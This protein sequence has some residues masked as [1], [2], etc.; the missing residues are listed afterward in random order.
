MAVTE[1]QSNLG[2]TV[3]SPKVALYAVN[4]EQIQGK[5]SEVRSSGR[6]MTTQAP[7][8]V[9]AKSSDNGD[10]LDQLVKLMNELLEA[11]VEMNGSQS[12]LN[13]SQNAVGN[14]MVK[15]AKAQQKKAEKDLKELE[16]KI[17][18]AKHNGLLGKI[19]GGIAA[20]LMIVIGV[21]LADPALA[22]MGG[23]MMAMS[24]G[25]GQEALDKKLENLS[26]ALKAL[27]LVGIAVGA[28]I[29]T[30]GLA[31]GINGLLSETAEESASQVAAQSASS[32]F[33]SGAK[34]S[35]A[36]GTVIGN[37][38][39][40]TLVF[41]PYTPLVTAIVEKKSK[42]NAKLIGQIVGEIV[43][44]ISAIIGGKVKP[45]STSL[46]NRSLNAT[47]K[48]VV[49]A[50]PQALVKFLMGSELGAN[51]TVGWFGRKQGEAIKG[52]ADVI[53]EMGSTQ[54]SLTVYQTLLTWVGTIAKQTLKSFQAISDEFATMNSRWNSFVEPYAHVVQIQA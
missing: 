4:G 37:T 43:A 15:L 25:G 31:G 21:I 13:N 16:R 9:P 44:I 30:G 38:A 18:E 26:P 19:F 27:V 7:S 40:M 22:V 1:I 14:S 46:A 2:P 45:D 54:G 50:A 23:M 47:G 5:Q 34:E 51:F 17:E 10:Y 29:V 52:Q 49:G 11:L 41:N 48:K 35:F 24:V 53:R 12:K 20:G 3:A 8:L 42:K 33:A 39:Q 6:L 32:R 28:A 36:A